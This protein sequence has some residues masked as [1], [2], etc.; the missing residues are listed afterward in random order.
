[1]SAKLNDA[2]V[3]GQLDGHWQRITALLLHKL[4]ERGGEVVLSAEDMKRYAEEWPQGA[5]V[6]VD[7]RFDSLAFKLVTIE[8]ARRI[9]AHQQTMQGHA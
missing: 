3:L 4:V 5:I 7:G 8:E 2:P 9:A 1:M 6:M